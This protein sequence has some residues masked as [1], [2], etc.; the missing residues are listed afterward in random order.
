MELVS[1]ADS[2]AEE[3]DQDG[4]SWISKSVKREEIVGYVFAEV[5]GVIV[6]LDIKS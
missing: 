4:L 3:Q 5:D 1:A 2:Q 6:Q